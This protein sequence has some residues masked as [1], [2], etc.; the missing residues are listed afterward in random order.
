MMKNFFYSL[1]LLLNLVTI[2][3]VIVVSCFESNESSPP[4][5]KPSEYVLDASVWRTP[6]IRAQ[7]F[8]FEIQISSLGISYDLESVQKSIRGHDLGEYKSALAPVRAAEWGYSFTHLNGKLDGAGHRI[9]GG[10]PTPPASRAACLKVID[11]MARISAWIAWTR[12]FGNNF[13]AV[14]LSRSQARS[15]TSSMSRRVVFM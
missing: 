7:G 15:N 2:L 5:A 6:P 13:H 10:Y 14:Y 12:L 8:Q 1:A 9:C 3:S 4:H 11:C